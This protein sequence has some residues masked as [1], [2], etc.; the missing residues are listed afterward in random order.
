ML[1]ITRLDSIDGEENRVV[2]EGYI[3]AEEIKR[4]TFWTETTNTQIDRLF[5]L[6][7]C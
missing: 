7:F 1:K 3:F 4:A 6:D 5:K 2:I